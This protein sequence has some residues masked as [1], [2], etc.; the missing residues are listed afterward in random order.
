MSLIDHLKE[1]LPFGAATVFDLVRGRYPDFVYG[2]DQLSDGVPVF[3]FH[4][5]EPESFKAIL[6]FL[7]RNDYYTLT[8]AEL[9]DWVL[10]DAD[11]PHERSVL[12]SFDDGRG[13]VWSVAYP[14]L[15]RFGMKATVFLI[16]NLIEARAEYLPT[17]DDVEQG[18]ASIEAIES[19]ENGAQPFLTWEEILEMASSGAL[20]FES[21][22]FEHSL[23]FTSPKIVD[24]VRPEIR[25]TF[26]PLEFRIATARKGPSTVSPL[27]LGAPLY[28][29]APRL[30]GKPRYFDDLELRQ[31]CID[32]VAQRGGERFF[33]HEDW[34]D[35]LK[36]VVT[37]HR[38]HHSLDHQY[39]SPEETRENIHL[40]LA[41]SKKAIEER[42]KLAPVHFLA[43]PWGVGSEL[44]A[45]VAQSL[46]F[47][48]C[49]WERTNGRY[50]NE[51]GQ[52][53][54]HL[55]RMGPD[56]LRLLP[57]EGRDSLLSLFV[58]KLRRR[59][60]TPSPYLT[61]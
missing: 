42:P 36:S 21:H 47:R 5:A 24:F 35:Q 46:G 13:S 48:G 58:T 28:T 20:N 54:H 52:D 10:G 16:P 8:P 22:S 56:F 12:L 32:F 57:G 25:K 39:E 43:F 3:G 29:T 50:V 2:S 17:L 55:R 45:S 19:R 9:T 38:E 6:R 27:P 33:E 1:K 14:L 44:A 41:H 37:S 23:V 53:P 60:S 49:F 18:N 51:R 15:R 4:S 26:D 7:A 40:D 61:H 30:S 31:A 11:L 34:R 59:F